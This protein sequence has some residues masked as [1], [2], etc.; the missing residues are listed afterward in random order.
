MRDWHFF[1]FSVFAAL[2]VGLFFGYA[3]GRA[4]SIQFGDPRPPAPVSRPA[5]PAAR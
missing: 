2:T 1:W 4:V 5:T 3:A